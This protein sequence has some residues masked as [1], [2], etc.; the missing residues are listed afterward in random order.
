MQRTLPL[1]SSHEIVS[2]GWPTFDDSGIFEGPLGP[3][4]YFRFTVGRQNGREL[5]DYELGGLA[6]TL[7]RS[8]SLPGH[9]GVSIE[10]GEDEERE[11]R[12]S[13]VIEATGSDPGPPISVT[14]VQ[15]STSTR[16]HE[17]RVQHV[18]ERGG[19]RR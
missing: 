4:L 6:A 3:P 11:K 9:S 10:Q 1:P 2:E 15:P 14:P 19:H 7:V 17:G 5:Q 16:S 13:H 18:D 12:D 8:F